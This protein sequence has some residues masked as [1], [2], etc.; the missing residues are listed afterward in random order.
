MAIE[1][2]VKAAV[3]AWHQSSLFWSLFVVL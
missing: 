2:N 3:I 1:T